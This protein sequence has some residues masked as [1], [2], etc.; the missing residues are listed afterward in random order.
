ME[1]SFYLIAPHARMTLWGD[2]PLKH[3]LFGGFSLLVELL[4]TPVRP[5]DPQFVQTR[6]RQR[7]QSN[8]AP[9]FCDLP[10]E[11]H[12]LIFDQFEFIEDVVR[13]GLA[14]QYFWAL[15]R[16]RL[17]DYYISF[18]GPWAGKNIVCVGA[19]V[20]PDDYPPGLFSAEELDILRPLRANV[21]LRDGSYEVVHR[22]QP[23]ALSH[24]AEPYISQVGRDILISH[25]GWKRRVI[26][27]RKSRHASRN[28][29]FVP[30]KWDIESTYYPRDQPWILRNLTTKEFVRAEAIAMKPEYI[31]GPD[32]SI[33]GFGEVVLARTCWS[34]SPSNVLINNTTGPP[35]GAWA[36][37]RLDI[38]TLANHESGVDT[39]G[40]SDVSEEVAKEIAEIWREEFKV[41]I[42]EDLADWN[43]RRPNAIHHPIPP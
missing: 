13:L 7:R 3:R 37:H 31:N 10:I 43:S 27:N 21:L 16:S 40:W 36:G 12:L 35:R 30:R 1:E 14:S 4:A 26:F 15:A 11:I 24:F 34:S 8:D 25:E 33:V 5:Q 39:V 42:R 41:D 18:L 6:P 29:E 17:H 20:K 9:T 38:T 32:I 28:S 2:Q 22:D 23:F 19:R